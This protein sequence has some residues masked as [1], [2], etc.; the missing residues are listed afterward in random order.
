MDSKQSSPKDNNQEWKSQNSHQQHN[1]HPI[2][3]TTEHIN[4]VTI[5]TLAINKLVNQESNPNSASKRNHK[6]SDNKY[7]KVSKLGSWRY[8]TKKSTSQSPPLSDTLN[9]IVFIHIPLSQLMARSD[10][11]KILCHIWYK[12]FDLFQLA[13]TSNDENHAPQQLCLTQQKQC[14]N[15]KP[16]KF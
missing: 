7:H 3:S 16:N 9:Q 13:I 10:I 2:P 15:W 5:R 8:L 4:S 1:Y 6:I 12:W 11:F 14:K